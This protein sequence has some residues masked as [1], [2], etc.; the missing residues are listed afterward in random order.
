[1]LPIWIEG[2]SR[3]GKTTRL[4]EQ[5]S[6]WFDVQSKNF[7][8]NQALVFVANN[9]NRRHLRDL[10]TKASKGNYPINCQTPLGFFQDEITLFWPLLCDQLQ[11]KAQ[12]PLPLRPETE[13]ELAT[14]LWRNQLEICQLPGISHDRMVRNL[15]DVLQ[16]AGA[17]GV[18]LDQI[19]L[20]LRQG[21]N[22]FYLLPELNSEQICSEWF[23]MLRKW[24]SWSLK[25]GFLTYGLV[26]YLYAQ[27]LLPHP[28]YQNY[29][30]H[31][32]SAIF[33]DDLDDYPAIARHFFEI[34]LD[35]GKFGVFTYNPS[36]KV[37][38][39]INADPDYLKN[40]ANRCETE[41][42]NQENPLI[43]T[44]IALITNFDSKDSLPD[45]VVQI[46]AIT[47]A[48][49]LRKVSQFI[50]TS[51]KE[52]KISLG[53]I[54]IIAP[55]LDAIARYSFL[56][57]LSSQGMS[58]EPLNEQRPLISYAHIRTLLTLL[59]L[60]DEGLAHLATPDTVAEM[61]VILS[62]KPTLQGK[63]TP[64]I[65][66]VRAAL[67][68]DYC[69]EADKAHFLDFETNFPRWD[70]LGYKASTAYNQI[71]QW[72]AETKIMVKSAKITP[73]GILDKAIK[74]FYGNG[75]RFNNSANLTALRELL[76][77]AEHYWEVNQRT[78]KN[79]NLLENFVQLLRQGTIT[80][81]PR[82]V[83]ILGK[84]KPA[85]TLATIFQYRQE[86]TSHRWHFW[87]DT[88][89]RLWEKGGSA[90]LFGAPLFLQNW[91]GQPF[92]W[93]KEETMNR[94]RLVRIIRDLI[95][96]NTEKIYL[97]SSHLDVN[98]SEQIS[99]LSSLNYAAQEIDLV[100]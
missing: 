89:S 48:S 5:F 50:R 13:Q 86:R 45:S 34:L 46:N 57:M 4:V 68:V 52:E 12:F 30:N 18:K 76:E 65:D 99:G 10:L 38:L 60:T 85:I 70:R 36:G 17:S 78:G 93:E 26:Y 82:P 94:K 14:N 21:L 62:E 81:N 43:E 1:M 7:S 28:D 73:L 63:L 100:S 92:T 54:A 88:N 75:T 20:T 11:I 32:Y 42:L 59:C 23:K 15:L 90:N 6:S 71:C 35:Q 2:T 29:L 40:I 58:I 67:L 19:P 47:R 77:T 8:P 64:E 69:Y 53:E 79:P 33:A 24:Y 51:I 31:K 61:L 84:H 22:I 41:Q 96:R 25:N 74:D 80:A 56:E 16:L 95:A 98:G 44:A 37:R 91:D 66:P 97:C 83:G 3:T 49:L 39:G 55:G 9:H 27:F 87:L 72:L